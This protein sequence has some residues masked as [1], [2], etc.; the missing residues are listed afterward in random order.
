MTSGVTGRGVVKDRYVIVLQ[1]NTADAGHQQGL[2]A[3]KT[4]V[5]APCA[6]LFLPRA[7]SMIGL[8]ASSISPIALSA[9]FPGFD[10][11]LIGGVAPGFIGV[12]QTVA[13]TA[14]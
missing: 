5:P 10:V 14:D 13:F 4:I 11:A 6:S 12:F 9:A 3:A 1:I 8:P 2:V 7:G